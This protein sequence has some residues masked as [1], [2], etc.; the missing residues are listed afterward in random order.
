MENT[1]A[2][3][4]GR[5][6]MALEEP[7]TIANYALNIEK[8]GLPKDFYKTYLERINAV[9]VDEVQ[10]VAQKYIHPLEKTRESG[11]GQGPRSASQFLNVSFNGKKIPVKYFD[12][13]GE[14]AE[15]PEDTVAAAPEGVGVNDS[16]NHYIKAIGGKEKLADVES[17][18]M[19]AEAEMQ[20]MKLNLEIKKTAHGKFMQDVKV[21]G[22]SMSK[23]VF[24]GEKGYMM[25][26]GQHKDMG[27]EE[28]VQVQKEAAPFPELNYLE[29]GDITLEGVEM[30]K[31][32]PAYKLKLSDQK[33]AFYDRESGL[34]VQETTTAEMGGQSMTSTINL[35]DYQEFPATDFPLRSARP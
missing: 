14:P 30:V 23:Q 26:Q 13:K 22:N 33:S 31:G 19:T 21:G 2:K 32:K 8:E 10:K 9:T 24:D 25:M 6:V 27:E 29:D 4:A 18:L 5:F 7:Q 16:L 1:K 28:I 35:S 12:K 11:Y 17:Y 34:K 15:K 3:Y 20:G